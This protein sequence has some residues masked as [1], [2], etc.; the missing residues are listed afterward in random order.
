MIRYL[1]L[2]EILDLHRQ[3]IET[4]GG[5]I[6]HCILIGIRKLKIKMSIKSGIETVLFA[7]I[8]R[9]TQDL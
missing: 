9:S 8:A 6:E 2:I 4:S 3:V 1:S 7:R 5:A